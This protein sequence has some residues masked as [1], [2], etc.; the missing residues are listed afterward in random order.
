MKSAAKIPKR[1]VFIVDDHPLVRDFLAQVIHSQSDLVVC[2]EAEDARQALEA[3]PKINPDVAIVDLSLKQSHGMDLIKDLHIRHPKLPVLVLSMHDESVFAERVLRAGA[4]GY[5]TKQEPASQI[6]AALRQVL[7]NE[8]YLS[9]HV[10]TQLVGRSLTPGKRSPLESLSDRE[11]QILE[12]IGAG[13][14]TTQIASMLHLDK[15]TIGTYRLRLIRKL[16]LRDSNELIHYAI[17]RAQTE[18][19]E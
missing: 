6:L 15:K 8:L 5:I 11:L 13:Y 3:I 14:K 16:S 1:K 10:A 2:G 17:R 19:R 4:K 7:K 18:R 9:E 12:L